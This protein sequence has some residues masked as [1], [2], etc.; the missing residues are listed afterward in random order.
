MALQNY[1]DTAVLS[2]SRRGDAPAGASRV[3]RL[4][5]QGI[6]HLASP[7]VLVA[8]G[9]FATAAT[10]GRPTAFL[11]AAVFTLVGAVL[12]LLA[13]LRQLQSGQVADLELTRRH[14]RLW[15]MLLTS[16]CVGIGA[17]LL[18]LAGAPTIVA[19]LACVLG[20]LCLVL[21][22]IT[23]RWKISVHCATVAATAVLIW[24]LT[25]RLEP[26]LV[27]LALMIWSRLYLRRHT[28]MQCA[29]GSLL[30]A[31]LFALAWP[32]LGG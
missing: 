8:A 22:A 25:G 26:G 28:A 7:P 29:A 24:Q 12:P 20:M 27:L 30:G 18:Q 2:R 5:A 23:T 19:G 11:A 31:G 10:D 1:T 21:L 16:T 17:G 13:L 3:L 4:A 9:A 32:L 15:P 14:Q 6:S